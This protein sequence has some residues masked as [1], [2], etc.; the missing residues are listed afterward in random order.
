MKHAI[1]VLIVL[2]VVAIFLSLGRNGLELSY[3]KEQSGNLLAAQNIV[4]PNEKSTIS[5]PQPIIIWHFSSFWD[6]LSSL[7]TALS[8]GLITHV[9]IGGP[10]HRKDDG[11]PKKMQK[12]LKAIKRCKIA[13]AKTI[14]IRWLWPG[15]SI[16]RTRE[17]YLFDPNFYIQEINAIRA[18]GEKIGA[19]F[20]AFD[21]EAYG[22]SPLSAY[23]KGQQIFKTKDRKRLKYV[24]EAAIN[25]AGKVDFILPAGWKG[26]RMPYLI[27][28]QLGTNRISESTYY[29]HER[30]KNIKTPYEIFGAYVN[31]TRENEH[32]KVLPYFLIH[33][34]F[35]N[36]HLW[37]D[38]KGLWLY[39][40]KGKAEAL[41]QE[42]VKYA[43]SLP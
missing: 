7:E 40:G 24:V 26:N 36:S 1:L 12:A 25:E 8:S 20:V 11:D 19:D 42:L 41:A 37:S 16:D 18:E 6:S 23:H 5:K 21:T 34:I 3:Q 38:K 22:K 33:E 14:W 13:G 4:E 29:N 9:S 27:L 28:A 30:I 31:T 15:Y 39:H 43:R 32:S 35:D 10:L 2:L 17:E